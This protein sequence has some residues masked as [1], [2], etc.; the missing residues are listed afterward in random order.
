VDC[1]QR[2]C[3]RGDNPDTDCLTQNPQVQRI[4]LSKPSDSIGS[5]LPST[6]SVRFDF[7]GADGEQFSA[8]M[9]DP[10]DGTNGMNSLREALYK[11]PRYAA[12]IEAVSVSSGT[13]TTTSIEYFVTFH[14]SRVR[15]N[16]TL[17]SCPAQ[18]MC[19]DQGCAPQYN[20]VVYQE[21][22]VHAASLVLNE[23]SSM[24]QSSGGLTAGVEIDCNAAG[25]AWRF[26]EIDGEGAPYQFIDFS[27]IPWSEWRPW[28]RGAGRIAVP[29]GSKGLALD[30]DPGSVGTCGQ[31]GVQRIFWT[32]PT[33]SITTS[34]PADTQYE[35]AVC[36][37]R[38]LCDHGT[39]ECKCMPGYGGPACESKI[40]F[41]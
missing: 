24:L 39:G 13:I 36:S 2:I 6:A 18:S 20:T 1:T 26:R 10:S 11:L 30:F 31:D 40:T 8:V 23:E 37:D 15:G 29:I 28:P 25:T 33:C 21:E 19:M 9:S 17:L 22:N 14:G 34:S 38:G 16:Q 7:N 35:N 32:V 3:P 41:Q 12:G 27:A 5:G 4:L